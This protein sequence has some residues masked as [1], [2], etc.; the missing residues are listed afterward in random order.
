MRELNERIAEHYGHAGPLFVR[1]LVDMRE[2]WKGL[3]NWY[4]ELLAEYQAQAGSNAV[5][6][7]MAAYFSVLEIAECL[8][9]ELIGF[10]WPY[11]NT[12]ANLWVE[13]TA[14][15]HEADRAAAALRFVMSWAH[16]HRSEFEEPRQMGFRSPPLHGWAGRRRVEDRNQQAPVLAIHTQRLDALLR[17]GKFEPEAIRRQWRDRQWLRTTEGR[18]TLKVR[19]DGNGN[20]TAEMVGILWASIDE[21]IGEPDDPPEEPGPRGIVGA[22]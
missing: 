3:R 18:T 10:P 15:S 12:I 17:E 11:Q 8:A 20:N 5:A 21:L 9:H 13:L 19:C 1:N 7:R 16:G 6:S 14:D 4:R 22:P 2:D